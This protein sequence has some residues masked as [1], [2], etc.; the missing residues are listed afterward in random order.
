MK[1]NDIANSLAIFSNQ[2]SY[3][4][5]KDTII[6]ILDTTANSLIV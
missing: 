5:I 4:D 6:A 3:Q 1:S 2:T